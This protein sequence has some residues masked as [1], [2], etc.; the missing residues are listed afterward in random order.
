MKRFFLASFA[1]IT[2][3]ACTNNKPQPIEIKGNIQ[4]LETAYALVMSKG[5]TDTV[6]IEADGN[7]SFNTEISTPQYFT[8]RAGRIRHTFFMTPGNISIISLNVGNLEEVPKFTGDN[9][10]YNVIIR[11]ANQ[12]FTSLTQ[13]FAALYNLPKDE[14]LAKL[15]SAKSEVQKLI[16]IAEKKDKQFAKMEMARADYKVKELLYNY[17]KY[18]A[19]IN[20]VEYVSN[21]SDHSFMAEVDFNNIDHISINE[22]TSLVFS[23]LQNE[24]WTIISNDSNK[25]ISEFEQN[26]I[27]FDL[28]DSLVSDPTLRDLY[29][30]NQTKETIVWSSIEVA[31]NIGNHFLGIATFS[32]YKE[33]IEYTL[34]KRMLLAPGK[35]APDFTLEC[36][37]GETYSLNDFKGKLVYIDFW[38]TWCSPCRKE[39]PYLAKLK[40][41]YKNKPIVF[42]AISLDDNKEAWVKMVTEDKLGGYQLYAQKAWQSDAAQQ[43][44]ISGVPTF[45]LIDAEGKIIQYPASR[46]S[47]EETPLLFDKHLKL[48]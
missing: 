4:N 8:L 26:L 12:V 19:L 16:P 7:F 15:D 38:A 35:I 48:M 5:I 23:H 20:K 39:I 44:Q 32:P 22:Y 34:A 40:E 41:A 46:P 9:S 47:E 37:D 30:Y 24:Y 11:Q 17:P 27:F 28:V 21:P 2:F 6:K 25:G 14:F 29:K 3:A 42:V 13:N 10:E 1:L 33:S 36:I 18:N 43:Y 31:E 45:V